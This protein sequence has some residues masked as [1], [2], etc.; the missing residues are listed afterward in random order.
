[1]PQLNGLELF[2]KMKEIN[3]SSKLMLL[4]ASHEQL[5]TSKSGQLE[6]KIDRKPVTITSSLQA[7]NSILAPDEKSQIARK[8]RWSVSNMLAYS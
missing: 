7:I 4:T 1:M 2:K 6:F 5:E 3:R 8:I